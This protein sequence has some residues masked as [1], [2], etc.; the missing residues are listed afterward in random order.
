MMIISNTIIPAMTAPTMYP[1]E[2]SSP[3]SP[4]VDM[5]ILI[6]ICR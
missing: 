1:T 4:N 3:D 6:Q 5:H 2:L